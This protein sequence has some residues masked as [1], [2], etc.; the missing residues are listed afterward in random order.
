MAE[1]AAGARYPAKLLRALARAQDDP[2]AVRRVG[3][4]YASEQCGD[5]LDN[6]VKGIHFYTLN[7]SDA[8]KEI[9]AS[10]G[11]TN[12]NALVG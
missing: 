7:Q 6:N 12:S 9:Y 3:I 2:E 4:H 1:L 8:T 5:L 10:L 11:L